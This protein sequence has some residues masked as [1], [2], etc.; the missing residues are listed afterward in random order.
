VGVDYSVVAGERADM[1]HKLAA[2][3]AVDCMPSRSKSKR[4]PNCLTKLLDQQEQVV[5]HCIP[6]EV[7]KG[8]SDHQEDRQAP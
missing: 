8:A 4:R 1:V 5:G 3:T 2:E 7:L 6:G